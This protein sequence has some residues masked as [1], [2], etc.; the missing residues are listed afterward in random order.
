M[1]R[2]TRM[3]NSNTVRSSIPEKFNTKSGENPP[4]ASIPFISIDDGQCP[5]KFMRSTTLNAP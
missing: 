2:P 1:P 5:P 4:S 3:L